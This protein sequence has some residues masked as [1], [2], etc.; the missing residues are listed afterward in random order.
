VTA[1]VRKNSSVSDQFFSPT[2]KTIE[3]NHSVDLSQQVSDLD[4]QAIVHLAT[5]YSTSDEIS[6]TLHMVDA[7]SKTS[8]NIM[9]TASE[10]SIPIVFTN[11]YSTSIGDFGEPGSIYALLKSFD[12]EI[13]K[14]FSNEYG[15]RV[16]E[17][18][19]FDTYGVNDRRKKFL[20][21]LI[22]SIVANE[23]FPASG[24]EQLIDL[25]HVDDICTAIEKAILELMMPSLK[26]MTT[27]SIASRNP[28]TLQQLAEIVFQVTK[29][30]TK[31]VWGA[32]P[33]RKYEMFRYKL[34]YEMLP[35][36]HPR[37]KLDDGIMEIYNEL[38]GKIIE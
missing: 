27:Y 19:L 34:S 24:G 22:R 12:H 37:K 13:A 6:Q 36:W 28:L 30:N 15:L 23:E 4:I 25:T 20:T 1:C 18:S 29:K 33:Y 9:R 31:V 35:N 26:C 10:H 11:S 2:V 16:I 32:R 8:L 7:I 5:F 21:E 17:L 38:S 14:Y 3:W